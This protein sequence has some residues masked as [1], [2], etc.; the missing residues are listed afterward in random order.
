M[1][2]KGVIVMTSDLAH[3]IPCYM[4]NIPPTKYIDEGIFL[5]TSEL[6]NMP[7]CI[8]FKKLLSPTG[9][10]IGKIRT[11]KSTTAKAI[12][13]RQHLLYGTKIL[14][15]DPHGEYA[16][17]VRS[18]GGTVIDMRKEKINPC[19]LAKNLTNKQKAH[20][21]V[22]M[23]G[24][25][26]E[27]NPIQRYYLTD[28]SYRGFE[29]LGE[30]LTFNYIIDMLT[31]ESKRNTSLAKTIQ[32]IL[33][34]I[35]DITESVFG[36]TNSIPIDDI[37]KGIVCIDLSKLDSNEIRN[38]AMLSIL[39]YIYNTMLANQTTEPYDPDGPLRLLI[40]IDEAG[41]IASDESSSAVKLVKESGKF[42]IGLIFGIQDLPD[43]DPKIKSNYGFMI[44]HKLDDT[45]YISKIQ[46]DGN[47]TKEQAERIRSLAVGTAYLKLNFKDA[48]VQRPFIVRVA[49]EEYEVQKTEQ[50]SNYLIEKGKIRE[51]SAKKTEIRESAEHPKLN[52]LEKEKQDPIHELELKLAKSIAANP[53]LNVTQHYKNI[54]TDTYY[55]NLARQS[56]ESKDYVKG[57]YLK[58]NMK[59]GRML[60]L[61]EKGIVELELEKNTARFGGTVHINV[62][63]SVAEKFREFGCTVEKEKSLGHNKY[64]DLVV[65]SKIAVEVDMRELRESNIQKNLES[66]FD[67]II[68][69]CY[70]KTQLDSFKKKLEKMDMK[71]EDRKKITLTD[72]N[73]FC[74]M[75]TLAEIFG[76]TNNGQ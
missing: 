31:K 36:D 41:R 55:G 57:T 61:T 19:Q 13:I 54:G 65:N 71:D 4:T 12:L 67:Q 11:G 37:T 10:I 51:D 14:I 33:V 46:R 68:E 49:R 62:V 76:D 35:W 23:L 40:M 18:V 22:D 59:K 24:T 43:L 64:A 60:S 73:T 47:F 69:I 21:L 3:M 2:T 8:S 42:K 52:N 38:M 7:I 17:L 26:F 6:L 72:Y 63:E 25:V 29:E 74:K 5:G 45:E 32:A 44:V 66:G 50:N 28:Y 9:L 34:R 27:L 1:K 15:F 16:D 75:K 56:L 70:E 30:N 53:L 58:G 48:S 20:Q 39:Q